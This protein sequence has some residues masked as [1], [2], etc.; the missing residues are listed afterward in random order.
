M[1]RAFSGVEARILLVGGVGVSERGGLFRDPSTGRLVFL[2]YL[3]IAQVSIN[4]GYE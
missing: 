1:R 3:S 2:K 4:S